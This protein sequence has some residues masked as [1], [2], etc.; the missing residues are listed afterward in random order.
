MLPQ[1]YKTDSSLQGHTIYLPSSSKIGNEKLPVFIWGNGAC[2]TV[3]T[4]NVALLE[5]IASYGFIA[6]AEG[7]PNGGGTSDDNTMKA[8]IDWVTKVAGTGSYANVDA[9]KIMTGGFS[10]GGVE[11]N[12]QIWDSRVST[13]GIFSSGLLSNQSAAQ[14]FTKPILYCLG[15]S[16]DVAYTNVSTFFSLQCSCCRSPTRPGNSEPAKADTVAVSR[17]SVTSTPCPPTRHHGRA[18]CLSV[19]AAHWAM[20]TAANLVRPA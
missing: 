14:H 7:T 20:P 12:D 17:E 11:A 6:I 8:A 16:G 9:S 13:I 3:G 2:S 10:C 15:G 19:T 1:N 18:T 4:S 5:Q